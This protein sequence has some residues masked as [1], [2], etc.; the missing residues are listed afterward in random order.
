MDFNK[1]LQYSSELNILYVEDN[2]ILLKATS[3]ILEDFFTL[4]DT[5]TNGADALE[6]YNS[7]YEK[8]NQYYDLIITDLNMP[9]M[10]GET[11]IQNINQINKEQ[12]IVVISAYNEAEKLKKLNDLG[13][14]D[15]VF[16]PISP[17][18]LMETLYKICKRLKS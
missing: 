15:F 7:Y 2:G 10:D 9:I 13:V 17:V 14:T 6:K 16:K 11:L 4:V 1:V 12:S 5:S 8:T 18:L 3:E